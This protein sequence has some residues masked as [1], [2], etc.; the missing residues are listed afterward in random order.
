LKFLFTKK[1]I[2]D[3]K[4]L[5]LI[6]DGVSEQSISWDTAQSIASRLV[7]FNRGTES[8]GI[9]GSDI[10]AIDLMNEIFEY[11]I[12]QTVNHSSPDFYQSTGEQLS[13][14]I[15]DQQFDDLTHEV[16]NLVPESPFTDSHTPNPYFYLYSI[17][18]SINNQNPAY[19]PYSLL[20]SNMDVNDSLQFNTLI[21]LI[22]ESFPKPLIG[23][24]SKLSMI[25]FLSQPSIREPKSIQGQLQ[26]ILEHWGDHLGHLKLK[27]LRGLD[28]V[29]EE[30][31][32]RG[33]GPGLVPIL[34][35][36]QFADT[37]R[38]STDADW[39]P[40]VI[41]LAKNVYVWLVQLSH[42][43]QQEIRTLHDIPDEELDWLADSG[44]TALWLIGIW[45]RS[46]ASKR[47]KH[48]C[49]NPDAEAS[50]YSLFD[51]RITGDLGGENAMHRLKERCANRGIRMACDMVPNH[52]GIDSQWIREHPDWYVQSD[53]P[54]FPAYSFHGENLSHDPGVEIYLE[55]HYYSRNDASV[56][57]KYVDKPSGKVR[58]I[59]HGNDGTSMPWNDTAQLN[60]LLPEVREAATQTVLSIARQFPIIRFDAAMTLA[61]Q[62]FQRLWYP[63][64]GTGSDIPSRSVHGLTKEQFDQFFPEEFWRTVVDRVAA[65]VPDTLLLAEAFWMMEGYFVRTLG[66]HRVYNSAFM[67]M[68]KMEENAKYRQTI[69]NVLS[70][71]PEI[72][73]RF[74]NFLNNPDEESAAIQFGKDDK[75]FGVTAMM[76]TMPGTP[77]FGHGQVEGFEEK[78]GMEFSR[79]YQDELPDESLI[80]RHK[81]EIFPLLKVRSLFS[82]SKNFRFYDFILPDG[83]IN[84]NVF[85]YSNGI[86]DKRVIVIFNNSFERT[87]GKI[88]HSVDI[89]SKNADGDSEIRQ[90]TI[91]EALGNHELES[92][93][94]II[95]VHPQGLTYIRSTSDLVNKGLNLILSGYE[96]QVMFIDSTVADDVNHNLSALH[97]IL[98]G[99]GI[100]DYALEYERI[101][102]R[103]LHKKLENI[104]VGL[105]NLQNDTDIVDSSDTMENVSNLLSGF[106][107]E[108]SIV[109]SL[110]ISENSK[111]EFLRSFQILSKI[112]GFTT[113]LEHTEK[114]GRID[115]E[116]QTLGCFMIM[117]KTLDLLS[118]SEGHKY[119]FSL[120]F[121]LNQSLVIER[122]SSIQ[123][124]M[125]SD[126]L[127]LIESFFTHLRTFYTNVADIP[128]FMQN[129]LRDDQSRSYLQVNEFEGQEWFNK[130]LFD[131]YLQYTSHSLISWYLLQITDS[132]NDKIQ[133]IDQMKAFTNSVYSWVDIVQKQAEISGYQWS[134]FLNEMAKYH[135]K[136]DTK[137]SAE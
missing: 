22:D 119:I 89:S 21:D 103:N 3:L 75:Y 25:T 83:G 35:F 2:T 115:G 114:S 52:T 62:H 16:M 100:Q 120:V 105:S 9:F 67:N 86:G 14:K 81:R 127:S 101:K 1:S 59:Y 130:E 18:S 80:H 69:K 56:V 112:S 24:E 72:L 76:I 54:P 117:A 132:E 92:R 97:R 63:E 70:F 12:Q 60:Y 42:K 4:L 48:L 111:E 78:Y 125:E 33:A 10:Y 113:N 50:A 133:M 102:Y 13:Q 110:P 123:N 53:Y 87:E 38:Y 109:C 49:G 73:K 5:E 77:M 121:D 27:L 39:M 95:K 84:Q 32:Y 20:F 96:F 64:A 37:E 104:L 40:N 44:F 31:K 85:A 74:V 28:F 23:N 90:Y 26:W 88:H 135:S 45:E 34:D 47:I 7:E 17:I 36:S 106:W 61:K 29:A 46:P 99:K 124:L 41:M 55:D 51:Y 65:E 136:N 66:M 71:D 82:E 43:Y 129:H 134:L 19:Q 8:L 11:L 57:F 6:A 91:A 30:Q 58:Y 15:G 108:L 126:S 98:D 122:N 93:F 137:P 131:Q 68:L 128:D 107:A 94:V 116:M 79:P 118:K